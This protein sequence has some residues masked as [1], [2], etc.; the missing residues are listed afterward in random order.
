MMGVR[1]FV[2]PGWAAAWGLTIFFTLLA[3]QVPEPAHRLK[4]VRIVNR[5][6]LPLWVVVY[7][8]EPATFP[9][10]PGAIVCQPINDPPEYARMLA[11]ELVHDGFVVLS[12]DWQGRAPEENRQL[13]RARMQEVLRSDVA[14]AVGYLRGLKEVDA[15]RVVIAGHS[16]GGTLAIDAANADP[17]IVAVAAIGMEADVTPDEPRN[18][19]WAVGLYDEFR[20]LGR[21]RQVFRTSARAVAPEET[22][23]GDSNR[24]TARRLAVSP[25]ADHFNE[26]Q[27]RGI[28]REVASWFR[29]AAGLPPDSR[30]FTMEARGLLVM[31]A[32]FGALAGALLTLRRVVVARPH[33]RWV[34]RA[35]VVLAL[36]SMV[37][38]SR[39]QGPHFLL[40]AD[41]IMVLLVFV[42]LA[43]FF[44]TRDREEL[45][46]GGRY[47]LRVGLVVWASALA[48]LV[49][50]NVPYYFQH[51]GYL[52]R[53]PEFAVKHV[54][55]LGDAYVLDYPRPLLFSAYNPETLHTRL[56]VYALAGVEV[57]FPGWLLGLVARLAHRS[58]RQAG[59]VPARRPVPLAGAVVLV[60]LVAFLAGI[61]WLRL[62]QG[63]LTGESARTGLRFLLRFAVLPFF[64]F[65]L[66]WRW[67]RKAVP[68]STEAR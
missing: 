55:D 13:L 53:L 22:T 42:L 52:A 61:L 43:G 4:Y 62:E 41:A 3:L 49:I 30:P 28:H 54:L 39:V 33:E 20:G 29:Q 8:P 65:A 25:T 44:S 10:A 50:N 14:A 26:L 34:L 46:S 63:F 5:Q 59:A 47:A 36:V 15:E 37:F 40:A 45:K 16:V 12:F 60:V 21:M 48:T 23:L 32:M 1:R 6:G 11:L 67:T 19:L 56:W 17:A 7:F 66:L 51:P 27:D 9:R 24:G 64:I 58:P 68:S 38:L 35:A 18:I 31:L 57:L 2:P